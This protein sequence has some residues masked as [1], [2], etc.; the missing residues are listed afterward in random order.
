V[1]RWT[2]ANTADGDQNSEVNI[3]DLTPIGANLFASN[4]P[5]PFAHSDNYSL[6]D[7]DNNGE[8]NISD[9]TPLGANLHT[10]VSGYNIY[11]SA[12]AGDYNPDPLAPSTL[13]PIGSI[14]FAAAQGEKQFERLFFEFSVPAPAPD[15]YYWVRPTD[16]ETEG[17]PSTLAGGAPP[18]IT[19]MPRVCDEGTLEIDLIVQCDP[20]NLQFTESY[21]YE[22]DWEDDGTVDYVV[23]DTSFSWRAPHTYLAAGDY[24]I[25]VAVSS[26]EG[27]YGEATV[28][29]NVRL[30]DRS[31]F[32]FHNSVD[33][34]EWTPGLGLEGLRIVNGRPA[35]AGRRW[36][37]GNLLWYGETLYCRADDAGGTSWPMPTV[38]EEDAVRPDGTHLPPVLIDAGGN[39]AIIYD[40][41]RAAEVREIL[42]KRAS[43]QNGDAWQDAVVLTPQFNTV[44]LSG[45]GAVAGR[46]AVVFIENDSLRFMLAD[47]AEGSS[48]GSAVDI[49]PQ[50]AW[51]L[52]YLLDAA[53]PL[54]LLDN[55]LYRAIDATGNA[56]NAP[57]EVATGLVIRD[58]KLVGG[59]P[60]LL[61]QDPV[62]DEV[63]YSSAT[64]ATGA[65][66]NPPVAVGVAAWAAA[67]GS[68]AGRPVVLYT[69]Y[70]EELGWDYYAL[71]FTYAIH[72]QDAAGTVWDA[73]EMIA[74][75]FGQ[76]ELTFARGLVEMPNGDLGA[77]VS[78]Y[79]ESGHGVQPS[80]FI[81]RPLD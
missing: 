8:I 14:D 67:L 63:F 58:A 75:P 60:T 37:H 73:P 18:V 44:F 77:F 80:V 68:V 40:A 49:A 5:D 31:E 11:S 12:D 33:D 69:T 46:P 39:P 17:T 15:A 76:Y 65:A 19:V 43:D 26:Q 32:E 35:L 78:H 53:T 10:R 36:P 66:W 20:P 55:L 22:I 57:L 59:I 3:A 42:F 72:A 21:T 30:L 74:C 61:C 13:T 29:A 50:S 9:L 62:T 24:T 70:E 47:Q 38:F 79:S 71:G 64:D 1:L 51:D 54:V 25:R 56:W 6:I 48:W 41:Y 2:Y 7:G 23:D 52:V 4:A 81:R 34:P 28:A 16:G 27:G 45:A